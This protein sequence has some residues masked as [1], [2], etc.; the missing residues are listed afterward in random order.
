MEKLNKR[1]LKVVWLICGGLEVWGGDWAQQN[2]LNM[3]F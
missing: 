1:G 3:V 2:R